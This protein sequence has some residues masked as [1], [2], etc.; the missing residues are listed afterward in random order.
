MNFIGKVRGFLLLAFL[1]TITVLANYVGDWRLVSPV[2]TVWNLFVGIVGFLYIIKSEIWRENN[3]RIN[4]L[5]KRSLISAIYIGLSCLLVAAK[6][7]S[8]V[9]ERYITSYN[10]PQYHRTLHVY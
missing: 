3:P 7:F 6:D 8:S 2:S 1:T 5:F 10:Y 9:E 4:N